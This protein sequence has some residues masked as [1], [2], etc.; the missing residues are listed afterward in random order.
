MQEM[1][2]KYDPSKN[3]RDDNKKNKR[4]AGVL[5]QAKQRDKQLSKLTLTLTLTLTL[6][7]PLTTHH[8]PL[9]THHSPLTT[10]HSPLTTRHSPQPGEAARQAAFQDGGGGAHRRPRRQER[11]GHDRTQLP[12]AAAAQ[13]VPARVARRRELPL[14]YPPGHTG[15]GRAAAARAIRLHLARRAHWC[16]RAPL[17]G[18]RERQG[19]RASG[20][21]CQRGLLRCTRTTTDHTPL[22]PPSLSHT[23]NTGPRQDQRRAN[24]GPNTGPNTGPAHRSQHAFSPRPKPAPTVRLA[25]CPRAPPP[26]PNGAGKSTLLHLL[27]QQ[28]QPT[29]GEAWLNRGAKWA[30]FAQHHIDQLDLNSSPQDFLA[31]KFAGAPPHRV[32]TACTPHAHRMHTRAQ[33]PKRLRSAH[34]WVASALRTS[35][36]GSR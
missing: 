29:S 15:Q 26:R 12:A 8:S 32:H 34:G 16:P 30:I 31:S 22:T 11:R 9:T 28:L 24:A 5:A 4:H 18:G 19:R 21:V 25:F 23:A 13:E 33:V 10:H 14:P 17:P 20:L 1:I 6:A 36:R 35:T 27:T 2:D 3:S 7:T